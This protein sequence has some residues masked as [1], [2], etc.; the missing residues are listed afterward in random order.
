MAIST[1]LA[2]EGTWH[3]SGAEHL[4]V[5]FSNQSRLATATGEN[6]AA[7]VNKFANQFAR[8]TNID[9]RAYRIQGL[10]RRTAFSTPKFV[11]TKLLETLAAVGNTKNLFSM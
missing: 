5:S 11:Q 1:V 8:I 10:H 7:N 2:S 4:T 6:R 3:P 9:G